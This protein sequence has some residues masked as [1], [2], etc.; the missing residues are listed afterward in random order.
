MAT[1]ARRT[2]LISAGAVFYPL[3]DGFRAKKVVDV[4]PMV[5]WAAGRPQKTRGGIWGLGELIPER[6][7]LY[8]KFRF[9]HYTG[10]G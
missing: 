7:E 5:R 2:D 8:L 10:K 4:G 1:P 6:G 3:R 9:G